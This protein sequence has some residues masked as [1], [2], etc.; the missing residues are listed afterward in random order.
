MPTYILTGN[1]TQ[2]GMDKIRGAPAR[3]ET[4]REVL[5]NLGGELKAWYV[6]T[7]ARDFVAIAE[8]PGDEI[9]ARW[10]LAMGSHGNIRVEF[11]RAFTEDEFRQI[12]S[13]L[14]Y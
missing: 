10:T 14:P 6:T 2:Q 8:A 1:H 5:G 9:I 13:Q 7:G 3:I 11:M 12:V 4:A